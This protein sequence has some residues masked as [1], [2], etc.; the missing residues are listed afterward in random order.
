MLDYTKDPEDD[1]ALFDLINMFVVW[2]LARTQLPLFFLL[3]LLSRRANFFK[4][5]LGGGGGGGGMFVCLFFFLLLPSFLP[6]VNPLDFFSRAVVVARV[7]RS[8]QR[9][10]REQKKK[11]EEIYA[12]FPQ[13]ADALPLQK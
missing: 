6:R 8:P 2:F 13:F 3:F 5:K 10:R 1:D 12:T 11:Q 7:Q 4:L 9:G